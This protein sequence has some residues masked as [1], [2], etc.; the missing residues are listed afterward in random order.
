MLHWVSSGNWVA[1]VM[2]GAW[3][4]KAGPGGGPVHVALVNSGGVRS[5]LDQGNITMADLLSTFP[6]QVGDFRDGSGRWSDG[7]CEGSKGK[8][9]APVYLFIS[10]SLQNTF[11]VVTLLGRD[12]RQALEHS[13]ENMWADGSGGEG[14]WLNWQSGHPHQ[15]LHPCSIF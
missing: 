9:G 8:G 13:V 4:G 11:D 7:G 12:L 14:R 1:D 2:V 6:F 5:S 10:F 15:I 3:A